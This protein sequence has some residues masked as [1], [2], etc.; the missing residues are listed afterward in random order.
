MHSPVECL[1]QGRTWLQTSVSA[2]CHGHQYGIPRVRRY[3][4]RKELGCDK[5][6]HTI[7]FSKLSSPSHLHGRK[8]DGQIQ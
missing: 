4:P 6:I 3:I 1:S 8:M 5:Y 2:N 7:A